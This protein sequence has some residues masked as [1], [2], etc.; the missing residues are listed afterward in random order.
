MGVFADQ[1]AE[2]RQPPLEFTVEAFLVCQ[3]PLD[4]LETRLEP[5]DDQ[6]LRVDG[7]PEGT[8]LGRLGRRDVI[9]ELLDEADEHFGAFPIEFVELLT[10]EHALTA[11]EREKRDMRG[12]SA[13]VD[14]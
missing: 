4:P 11:S 7:E 13:K 3:L 9:V 1:S 14:R 2:L 5:L 6:E 10:G 8:N 12:S